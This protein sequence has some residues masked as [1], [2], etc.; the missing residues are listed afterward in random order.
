MISA[1]LIL[2]YTE[3]YDVITFDVFDTLI[4]RDVDVPADIFTLAY[5]CFGRYF[6]ILAEMS[7]R[8]LSKFGDPS[9]KEIEKFFGRS[10]DTEIQLEKQYCRANPKIYDV[11]KELIKRGKKIYAI[12]DMYLSSETISEILHNAGYDIPVLVSCEEGHNKKTGELFQSFLLKYGYSA[13]QIFHIGDNYL[14]DG[15]GAKKAGIT[16]LVIEKDKNFL[17]YT[18]YSRKNPELSSFINHS[19]NMITIPSE[20]LG[21]EI[22]GPIIL[23]F[24]QWV[25][26]MKIEQGFE[27]LF[28]LARDMRFVYEVYKK[29]YQDDVRYLYV[30]RK[31]FRYARDHR[32]SFIK[33]LLQNECYGNVAIVDTGWA[34]TAQVEI[35]KYAKSII[36]N[37]DIGGLY[38][39]TRIAFRF[40]KRSKRSYACF[41]S[42][43]FEQCKCQLSSTFLESLI[44]TNEQQVIA[45]D[46][47]NPVFDREYEK[48][49][50]VELKN[51]ALKFIDDWIQ[52]KNN[53]NIDAKYTIHSFERLFLYPKSPDIELL[54]NITYEDV[55]KSKI[56]SFNSNLN[57]YK[58]PMKWLDDLS[59]STWKGGFFRCSFKHYLL[60]FYIYLLLNTL[61][62]IKVDINK[63]KSDN[64]D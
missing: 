59:Q 10:C 55:T 28:F 18:K 16:S 30:S 20:R 45:Y 4:I 26:K 13:D 53:K 9:L 17:A 2:K 34:G 24:C 61:R 29:I 38:M 52:I 63:I 41:F 51:G 42:S 7:A 62:N 3:E 46:D 6:R 32:D 56:V 43:F 50:Q 40:R 25:H 21:Y 60:L 5:G 64:F 35:D 14:A 54:R 44:G 1:D 19:L 27:R 49:P 23:S 48:L 12:S 57:Y 31:S 47:G 15:E 11:Y 8:H 37:S 39:G 58:N 36:E 22:I 33:Y